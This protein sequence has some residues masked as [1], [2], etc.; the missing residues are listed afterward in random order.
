MTVYQ[1]LLWIYV[2]SL[3]TC[4]FAA[5]FVNKHWDNGFQKIQDDCPVDLIWAIRMIGL[6]PI[7]N[8]GVACTFIK[9]LTLDVFDWL[10]ESIKPK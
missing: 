9:D 6:I 4:L 3:V 5:D 7:I 2:T 10:K 1:T 8:T